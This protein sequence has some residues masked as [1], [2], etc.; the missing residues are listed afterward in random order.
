MIFVLRLMREIICGFPYLS[1]LAN[2]KVGDFILRCVAPTSRKSVFTLDMKMSAEV[3]NG[4]NRQMVLHKY[5][6]IC[7]FSAWRRAASTIF[8]RSRTVSFR[9]VREGQILISR[10]MRF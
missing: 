2:E 1:G 7:G 6:E 3:K 5:E 9:A 4:G 10:A 8:I